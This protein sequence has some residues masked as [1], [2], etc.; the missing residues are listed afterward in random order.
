MYICYVPYLSLSSSYAHCVTVEMFFAILT[1]PKDTYSMHPSFQL[2]VD[3]N[4]GRHCPFVNLGIQ[5][6]VLGKDQH[7]LHPHLINRKNGL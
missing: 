4:V 1:N 7:G 2:I 5:G 3:T 6:Q